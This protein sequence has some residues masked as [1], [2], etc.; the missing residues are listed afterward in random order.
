MSE[1][2]RFNVRFGENFLSRSPKKGFNYHNGLGLQGLSTWN[3][4]TQAYLLMKLMTS[5]HNNVLS[6]CDIVVYLI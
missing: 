6:L 3:F 4:T 5:A 1:I 2:F